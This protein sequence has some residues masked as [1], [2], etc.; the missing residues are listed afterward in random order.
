S[1]FQGNHAIAMAYCEALLHENV[2]GRAE[3]ASEILRQQLLT[4]PE[5]PSLWALYARASNT[6]GK[7]VRAREAIA[8]SYF[9]RGGVY[10]ALAQLRELIN[11]DDLDYYQRARI[12]ARLNEI[13]IQMVKLDMDLEEPPP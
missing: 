11:S 4:H 6:A 5:D 9:L 2:E 8:E 1:G 3:T 13:Q 12:S 7:S 10:E